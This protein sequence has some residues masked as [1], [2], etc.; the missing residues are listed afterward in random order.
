[1]A[2]DVILSISGTEISTLVL[3]RYKEGVRGFSM[4]SI[5]IMALLICN[6]EHEIKKF[7]DAFQQRYFAPDT[8]G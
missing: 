8:H 1:L 4:L 3:S 6:Y 5:L 7:E 2:D